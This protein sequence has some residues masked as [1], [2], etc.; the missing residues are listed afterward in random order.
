M[1]RSFVS[2]R[3]TAANRGGVLLLAAIAVALSVAT[4]CTHTVQIKSV[5]EGADVTVDGEKVGKT[6]YAFQA[7]SGFFDDHQIKV[8]Q[9]GYAPFETQIVQSEP[10]WPIV[11]PSVCLSPL[12]LGMSCFGLCWG[13]RYAQAYEYELSPKVTRGDGG[14]DGAGTFEETE[15]TDPGLAIPY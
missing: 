13:F 5:P 12:T 2:T 14:L 9:E 8:E 4:G 10:I 15:E 3:Q 11:A 7:S 6:P 1:L